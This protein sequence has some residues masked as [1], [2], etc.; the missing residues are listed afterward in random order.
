MV[1]GGINREHSPS[2]SFWLLDVSLAS[3]KD[4]G[5]QL[6]AR[7][8][9]PDDRYE[10]GPS[11]VS[12]ALECYHVADRKLKRLD[13]IDWGVASVLVCGEE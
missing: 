5:Q 6:P 1:S 9:E 8:C 11:S 12:D 7:Y 2:C 4:R 13:P 10:R 3:H